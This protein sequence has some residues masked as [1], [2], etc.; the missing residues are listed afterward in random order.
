[1]SVAAP[2]RPRASRSSKARP[3]G[4]PKALKVALDW[5]EAHTVVPDGFRAGQPLELYEWQVRFLGNHYLV[6][7]D[8]VWDPDRP[9]LGPAF[10][11]RR[12]GMVGPQ[13][14]GKDPMEAAHI[15][16]EGDGPALFAGWAG[17]DDGWSC[18]DHGCACGWEYPYT[19]GEPMGMRWPTALIQVTAVSEDAT[20]NTYSALR[21]MIENGPLSYRIKKTSEDF[22]RLPGGGRIDVVTASATSRLGQRVTFVS[23]GEAGLYFKA[24][25]ML[26]VAD[27]QYRGL[28]GMGGRSVWHTNAW[29]PSEGSL[30]QREHEHPQRDVYLQFDRPPS[31]LS[32]TNR[33]ERWRIY[34]AV[35]PSDVR[36]EN[37]GHVDLD[38]IEAEALGIIAHDWPQAARFFGNQIVTGS[39]KA[40]DLADW[41]PLAKPGYL[42][43]SGAMVVLGFDGSKTGDHTALIACEV[44]TGFLWPLGVWDPA[45]HG[46]EVPRDAVDA[47]VD[48]AFATYRV[49]RMYADP[50]YWK[51]ELAG[52][53]G[54]YGDKVVLRWETYRNRPM[55]FAVRS[56]AQA[57][58][59]KALTHDADPRLT[60]HIGNA[61]RKPLN[62]RDD[63]GAPLWV[64]HK[65]T[66]DSPKKIDAA[67]AAVLAWEARNDVVATG[68]TG[69]SVYE[70]RGVL[71]V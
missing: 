67:V 17:K 25:K 14:L 68:A 48:E 36:R 24:N 59:D 55:G 9:I 23:Q 15:C 58:A 10:V 1:M 54:R 38:A 51:E 63:K 47:A 32:F 45:S 18:R 2:P 22:I 31:G 30:A 42:P 34:R 71:L 35:Y 64:L 29:D 12:S 5:I 61:S 8:A 62:E 4:S 19:P 43:Q 46:G 60:L 39:G 6:R 49:A 27:T 50:P 53:Q 20:A 33:E 28:A 13:K 70:S 26:A 3:P 56:F 21:P 52:W 44:T 69:P 37:G 11:H 7:P 40:F 41:D 66:P 65:E 16:L 57:I